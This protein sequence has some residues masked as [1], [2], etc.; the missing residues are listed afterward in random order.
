MRATGAGQSELSEAIIRG[1]PLCAL[2]PSRVEVGVEEPVHGRIADRGGA[3]SK[4]G[5]NYSDISTNYGGPADT[6]IL[7]PRRHAFLQSQTIAN[8]E[9]QPGRVFSLYDR[10]VEAPAM[11]ITLNTDQDA[12]LSVRSDAV[13][14][15]ADNE[16]TVHPDPGSGTLTVRFRI[17]V[18]VAVVVP[19]GTAV[20]KVLGTGT[21]TPTFA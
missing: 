11:P 15:F 12:L 6:L 19:L 20:G 9:A 16:I 3:A 8:G 1:R 13:H 5:S 18:R 4:L 21:T 17:L 2:A 7:A 10:V 14:V